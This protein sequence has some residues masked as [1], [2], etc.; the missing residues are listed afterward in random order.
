[1][2]GLV[3]KSVG[4]Q[5]LQTVSQERIALSGQDDDWDMARLRVLL[6]LRQETFASSL[7]H[8]QVGDDQVRLG[9]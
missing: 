2:Y 3:Q 7:R 9:R 4:T 5:I 6:N 8:A 1:M